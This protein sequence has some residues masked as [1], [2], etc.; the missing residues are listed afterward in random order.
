MRRKACT[1][2]LAGTVAELARQSAIIN[3][4]SAILAALEPIYIAT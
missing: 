3:D 4:S 1:K 2:L